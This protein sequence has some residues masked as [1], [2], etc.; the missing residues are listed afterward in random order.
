[1]SRAKKVRVGSAKPKGIKCDGAQGGDAVGKGSNNQVVV[2]ATMKVAIELGPHAGEVWS[3][4]IVLMRVL[5]VEAEK[6][7]DLAKSGGDP[8]VDFLDYLAESMSSRLSKEVSPSLA[9]QIW[10]NVTA[11]YVLIKK[12]MQ[13]R[14]MLGFGMAQT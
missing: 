8:T 1:M 2:D 9:Y 10:Q 12:N 4:D 13:E 6:R 14:Q 11:S 5:C 3:I 7:F